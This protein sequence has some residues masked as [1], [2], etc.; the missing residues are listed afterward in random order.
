MNTHAGAGNMNQHGFTLIELMIVVAILGILATIA[1]PA[2]QD[3]VIRAKVAE[4]FSL[5]GGAKTAVAEFRITT[6]SWPTTNARAGLTGTIVSKYVRS[7]KIGPNGRIIATVNTT[8]V[9]TSGALVLTPT[10][11]N[12]VLDWNC[13]THS[14]IPSKYLP[15]TCR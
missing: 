3:Y 11:T 9:G 15:A 2:Y 8:S 14:T 1:I 5:A 10:F 4:A 13:N 12:G 7:V 6:N